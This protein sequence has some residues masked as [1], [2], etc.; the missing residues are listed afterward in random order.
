MSGIAAIIRFDGGDVGSAELNLLLAG[1]DYRSRDGLGKWIKGSVALG[2]CMT[3]TTIESLDEVQPLTNEDQSLVLVM[4]GYL[5]NWE[6]LR[7]DLIARGLTLR[8]RSDSELVL[9]AYETW[10]QKCCARLEGEFAL[11]VWDSRSRTAFV[12]RDHAGLRPIHY[13][14]DS[15]RLIVAS[16][17]AP[18]LAMPGIA[19][20]PNYG[21]MAEIIAGQWMSEE[22]T[23][24]L[25]IKRLRSAHWAS[26]SQDGSKTERY[27]SPA[28]AAPII[29]KSDQE[30]VDHYRELLV[31]C[32]R[33]ASRSIRPLAFEVSGGL[34]S[35]AIF[36]VANALKKSEKLFAPDMVGFTFRTR[37]GSPSDEIHYAK[38]VADHLGASLRELPLF[39]P[40]LDWFVKRGRVDHDI[41]PYPNLAMM[42]SLTEAMVDEGCRVA[43]NGAGG[44]HW[45]GGSDY[46]YF[47]LLSSLN[48]PHLLQALGEDFAGAGLRKTL[49]SFLRSGIAQFLPRGI[50][51]LRHKATEAFTL[52]QEA[53]YFWLS[54]KLRTALDC[55]SQASDGKSIDPALRYKLALLNDGYDK[56]IADQFS[57]QAAQ[58]GMEL[59]SPMMSRPFIE[60]AFATPE[61]LRRRGG[62]SKWIHRQAI[63]NLLPEEVQNRRSKAHFTETLEV[64]VAAIADQFTAA[65]ILEA[66]LLTPNGWLRLL[67][68]CRNEDPN[69]RH[70]WELWGAF[71][72]QAL[73]TE[74]SRQNRNNGLSLCQR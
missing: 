2:H 73:A 15:Q 16:D 65:E 24:W 41:P 21:M 45:L 3:R 54:P 26:F 68:A 53:R 55:R 1:Q 52:K 33:R 71:G 14:W 4:D 43:L 61:R 34:D 58:I 72:C 66:G 27:W 23:I 19:P 46:Y 47:E 22:E 20:E 57:R 13:H 74:A 38:S 18:I 62:I 42:R 48:L 11:L 59:R 63:G 49:S 31:E 39:T 50:L 67:Q 56:L 7:Q 28:L 37:E 10:G 12:A 6:D 36:A 70:L 17:L 25:A 9:R 29:Y 44:D 35:S 40:P 60:F 5:S 32:V 64:Q 69:T 8:T 30:Y 51:D